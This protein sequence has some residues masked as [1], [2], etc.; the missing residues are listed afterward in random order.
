MLPRLNSIT[1]PLTL[2]NG[3]NITF[4]PFTVEE[5]KILLTAQ[6][7]EDQKL[8]LGAV[9]QI[10]RNCVLEDID[11]LS[12]PTFDLEYL[13]LNIRAKSVGEVVDLKLPHPTG[14]N[15]A[16]E[17]CEHR[18]DYKLN[19]DDVKVHKREGVSNNIKLDDKVGVILRY[20]TLES[21]FDT[22]GGDKFDIFINMIIGCIEKIYDEVNTY[23]AEDS[24]KKEL[25]D[26]VKSMNKKQMEKIAEFFEFMPKLKHVIKFRCQKCGCE[27]KIELEG[28]QSFFLLL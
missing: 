25:E 9:R 11:V 22:E 18:T 8:I 16:G 10:I 2:T 27:D 5:E 12:L 19:L 7:S 24:T 1:Y 4:K 20:P 28:L 6:E 15:S 13:F 3:K 26:F 17:V 21:A 14:K 23:L